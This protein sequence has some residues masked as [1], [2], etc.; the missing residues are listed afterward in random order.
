MEPPPDAAPAETYF[1]ERP[2]SPS[3][4]SHLRFLYRGELLDFEVD[5]GVF[6]RGGLD[7]GTELL[8]ESTV[9]RPTDQVLE[10]GCGWG[11][12]AVAA[13]KSVPEGRVVLTDVNRRA[14]HLTRRNLERNRITNAEVRPGS[15][16]DPVPEERFDLIVTNPPYR[17]GRPLIERLIGEAPAHLRPNGRFM[18]VGKGSEGI[19]FYQERLE[20]SWPGSVSVVGRG[21]GYRVLEATLAPPEPAAGERPRTAGISRPSRVRTLGARA[22]RGARIG[23]RVR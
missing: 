8:I 9:F 19:R 16:F 2:R 22:R 20:R 10:I 7:R 18:M 11:A 13:A 17:A 6:S 4:R 21:S 5:H 15:L 14:L 3:A 1:A 12:I 23:R